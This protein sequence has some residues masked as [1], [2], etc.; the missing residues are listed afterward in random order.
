MPKIVSEQEKENIKNAMYIKGIEL[1]RKKGMKRVTVD[2]IAAA[3]QIA[4]GS[5]YTY[6]HSKEEFLYHIMKQNEQAL[7][8]RILEIGSSSGHF[9][10]KITNALHEIYLA[11]DSLALY[12]QP[13]DMEYLL[14]KLPEPISR[15]EQDKSKTNFQRTMN[16]LG[17][18]DAQCDYSVLANLMDGLHFIASNQ[19]QYGEQGRAKALSI[20]VEAIAEYL[21]KCKQNSIK[22]G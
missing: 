9:K 1:I 20:L 2:D 19:N 22:N 7:F 15:E 12:V 10:E 11:P 17:I 13:S 14:R 3:V 21:S 5:F 8:D 4:K 18:G 6:Y 16:V